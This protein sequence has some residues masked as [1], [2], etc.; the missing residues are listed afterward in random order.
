MMELALSKV[1]S[2][3]PSRRYISL[4][5]SRR[6]VPLAPRGCDTRLSSFAACTLLRPRPSLRPS[7]RV[8]LFLL[9]RAVIRR[10]TLAV[11]VAT[12]ARSSRV[13]AAR[14]RPGRPS[15]PPSPRLSSRARKRGGRK[16]RAAAVVLSVRM[17]PRPTLRLGSSVTD[18]PTE[19]DVHQ[20]WRSLPLIVWPNDLF[21][22]EGCRG[23]EGW[24][25]GGTT[26]PPQK[27]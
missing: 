22:P 4:A 25:E 1:H 27:C 13:V 2:V 11:A 8:R 12:V 7:L 9:A 18:R 24:T 23:R 21:P 19:A 5:H 3:S 17:S 16:E 15:R 6:S 10:S 14:R 20:R 26:L